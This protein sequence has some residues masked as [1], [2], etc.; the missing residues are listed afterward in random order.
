MSY[1]NNVYGYATGIEAASGPT[2]EDYIIIV[3]G[4][5]AHLYTG[6]LEYI[7]DLS[8]NYP[9]LGYAQGVAFSPDGSRLFFLDSQNE[10]VVVVDVDYLLVIGSLSVP[11]ANFKTL[12]WGEEIVVA[13]DGKGFYYNTTEGIAYS[14]IDL[15]DV[16][17][18]GPDTING[19]NDSDILDG[20]G[21]ADT[22][23]G[24]DGDDWIIGGPGDDNIIGGPGFDIAAYD[25][26][27]GGVTVDLAI[28]TSQPTGQAG[29]DTLSGIEGLSGSIFSDTLYGDAYNNLLL[30][31]DGDDA[32]YGRDANDEIYGENGNDSLF[33]GNGVDWLFGGEGNDLLDGGAGADRLEGG[34][35]NDIYVV[36]NIGDEVVESAVGGNDTIRVYGVNFTLASSV[37]TLVVMEGAVNATGNFVAKTLIGS[38]EANVITGM[39]GNDTIDGGGNIDIAVVH[40][41]QSAYSVVQTS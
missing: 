20:L 34:N 38:D 7:V 29:S 25:T 14:S 12:K 19:T 28:Q 13:A 30:G 27:P 9:S 35:G 41:V 18:E 10:E 22:I 40:G 33:G 4:G 26:S 32:L 6:T 8:I 17:T 15:P 16:A 31:Y 3:T 36:D 39:G 37:E 2:A 1:A 11:G 24:L 21:G 23:Y 5:G